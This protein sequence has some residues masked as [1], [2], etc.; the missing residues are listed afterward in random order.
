PLPVSEL[1][2]DHIH[3]GSRPRTRIAGLR[4]CTLTRSWIASLAFARSA[5]IALWS[6]PTSS[7]LSDEKHVASLLLT[8]ARRDPWC[9]R[10][11]WP[12]TLQRFASAN[13]V[14]GAHRTTQS[15]HHQ[16]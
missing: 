12:R 1:V 7:S 13:L 5:R 8:T 14:L 11:S 10:P 16:T 9:P 3:A 2:R 4:A 15:K 6:S